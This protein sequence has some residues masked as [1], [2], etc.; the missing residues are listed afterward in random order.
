MN[1]KLP[2][3]F[4]ELDVEHMEIDDFG[5]INPDEMM[6]DENYNLWICK[7]AIVSK[8]RSE[9]KL[10]LIKRIETGFVVDIVYCGRFRWRR[11]CFTKQC[12]LPVVEFVTNNLWLVDA[13]I[14]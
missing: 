2:K 11:E 5:F 12:V 1:A 14:I 10:L 4:E 9:S 3:K 7:T 6:V 8:K 13:N